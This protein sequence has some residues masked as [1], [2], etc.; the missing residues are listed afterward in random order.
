MNKSDDTK[1]SVNKRLKSFVYAFNGILHL[2][3]SE[4]NAWIH[5]SA[6]IIVIIGG[7]LLKLNV[8]E[9]CLVIFAIGFVFTSELFNTSIE[10]LTDIVSPE[11]NKKAGIVKDIAAGAVL[12]SAIT[13][14]IIGVIIFLPKILNLFN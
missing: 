13:A 1:F 12:V 6:T 4:H 3:K 2:L 5:T 10:Y 8:F 11:Q 14:A 9:W 7:F